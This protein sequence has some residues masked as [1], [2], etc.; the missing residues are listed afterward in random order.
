MKNK[1][2]LKRQGHAIIIGGVG[3]RFSC[4]YY[5]RN[6]IESFLNDLRPGESIFDILGFGGPLRLN[7]T[8]T[9]SHARYLVDFHAL[10]FL[11]KTMGRILSWKQTT[12]ANTD[13]RL[14]PNEF[15]IGNLRHQIATREFGGEMRLKNFL[16]IWRWL[17]K[18]TWRKI[19]QNYRV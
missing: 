6:T 3:N 16:N 10:V 17:W 9:K 11:T 14:G 12:W 19:S 2:D 13:T 18:A 7:L 5:R 8:N 1:V 4:L 15:F